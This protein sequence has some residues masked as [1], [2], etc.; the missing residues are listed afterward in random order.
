[1]RPLLRSGHLREDEIACQTEWRA[2]MSQQ[3][4]KPLQR[5][6]GERENESSGNINRSE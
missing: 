2:G 5:C 6:R 3:K 4:E 1:M